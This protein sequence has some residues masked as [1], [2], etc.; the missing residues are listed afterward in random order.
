MSGLIGFSI[1]KPKYNSPIINYKLKKGKFVLPN[2][3]KQTIQVDICRTKA[4]GKQKNHKGTVVRGMY[5][6]KKK[7]LSKEQLHNFKIEL[8]LS[9]K[10]SSMGITKKPYILWGETDTWFQMPRFFGISKLGLP[11]KSLLVD[12]EKMKKLPLL[13]A[14][15]DYQQKPIET[16]GN[17]RI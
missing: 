3:K 2:A 11:E 15:R 1:K 16:N 8:T 17:Q 13:T 14:P 10:E 5:N 7:C 9:P 4:F 6:V 12:G